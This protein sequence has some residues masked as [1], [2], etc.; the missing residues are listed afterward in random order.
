MG[1]D[2]YVAYLVICGL[3]LCMYLVRSKTTS[4]KNTIRVII[5]FSFPYFLTDGL[6]LYFTN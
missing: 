2:H 3:L 6:I 1:N 5:L 4:Y